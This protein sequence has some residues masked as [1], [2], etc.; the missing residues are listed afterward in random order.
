MKF[1]KYIPVLLAVAVIAPGCIDELGKPTLNDNPDD[2][3]TITYLG[4][5]FMA[6]K[7]IYGDLFS[8]EADEDFT[9]DYSISPIGIQQAKH[10]NQGNQVLSGTGTYACG[11]L[12][13]GKY[14]FVVKELTPDRKAT[15]TRYTKDI[16]ITSYIS[17]EMDGKLSPQAGWKAAY[18]G[19]YPDQDASGA[20]IYC[21]RISSAGTGNALY[22]HVIC[23]SGAIKSSEDLL[24]AFRKGSGVDDL[25]GG[26]GLIDWYKM[27]AP[28]YNYLIGLDELLA[29]GGKDVDSGY[30]DYTL[31]TPSTGTFDIYTVEM[32]LN[33]HITGRYGK[34]TLEITGTPNIK[35]VAASPSASRT[36]RRGQIKK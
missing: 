27:I 8:V 15:G 14:V 25:R 17:Y 11:L 20:T 31:G 16:E 4:K 18:L 1:W 28:S 2:A 19:R 30:M 23:P 10:G 29:K 13:E 12:P 36:L 7:T 33:G 32:L 22:Y 9:Y 24:V 3:V 5:G 21:D 26:E 34:T 6:D 35:A